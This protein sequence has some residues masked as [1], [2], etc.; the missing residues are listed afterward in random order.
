VTELLEVTLR[1]DI[2]TLMGVLPQ[3]STQTATP[4]TG[5]RWLVRITDAHFVSVPEACIWAGSKRR[6]ALETKQAALAEYQFAR[7]TLSYS[8][9]AAVKWLAERFD[10]NDRQLF[11]WGLTETAMAS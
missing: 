11:R 5:G 1:L 2:R 6:K 4:F 8:H 10:V 7:D 3:G 9:A